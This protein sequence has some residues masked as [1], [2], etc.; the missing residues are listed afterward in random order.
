[1]RDSIRQDAGAWRVWAGFL[2]PLSGAMLAHGQ[3]ADTIDLQ[4]AHQPLR[5]VGMNACSRLRVHLRQPV[6]Q[7]LQPLACCQGFEFRAHRSISRRHV[8][9]PFLQR[10]EIQ[11]G[12]ADQQRNAAGGADLRHGRQRIAAELG[13]RVALSR[14]EDVH[15]AVRELRQYLGR[16]LRRADVHATVDQRR[17]D[18]D[19]LAGQHTRQLQRQIG[20]ARGGGTHEKDGGRQRRHRR[21]RQA[22]PHS[23]Q[24]QAAGRK[25]GLPPDPI[26]DRAGTACPDRPCPAASRSGGRGC[27]ARYARCAPCRAARHSS[28]AATGGGWHVPRRGRPWSPATR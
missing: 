13:S 4:R 22:W 8:R 21:A 17:I 12:S 25:H 26:S 1:M 16:G 10:L 9:Q 5:I 14:I 24:W 27:T 19:Q 6:V 7:H 15:Q 3:A 18:A 2:R 28:P 23:F 11:H 20:L